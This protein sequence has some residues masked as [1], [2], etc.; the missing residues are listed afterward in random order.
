[1]YVK[2]KETQIN[3]DDNL[4]PSY[5]NQEKPLPL[6]SSLARWILFLKVHK[7]CVVLSFAL[8]V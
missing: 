4:N 5:K 2:A 8:I 6:K 7:I 1:M 3:E